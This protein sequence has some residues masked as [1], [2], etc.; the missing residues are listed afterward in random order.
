M[1]G[2]DDFGKSRKERAKKLAKDLAPEV[3]RQ[4]EK[5]LESNNDEE[6]MK[7]IERRFGSD[8]SNRLKMNSSSRK[9]SKSE[10]PKQ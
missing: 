6:A 8:I 10:E 5:I 3:A 4:I 7:K 9:S 2:P 1:L